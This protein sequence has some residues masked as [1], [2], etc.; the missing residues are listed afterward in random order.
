MDIINSNEFGMLNEKKL[1]KFEKKIRRKLPEEYREFLLKHNGGNPSKDCFEFKGEP[2]FI[3]YVYG[4]HNGPE[5]LTLQWHI[6][7]LKNRIPSSLV[8]FAGDPGGNLYC[9][10]IS[11]EKKGGIYFWNHETCDN[12]EWTYILKLAETFHDF[13]QNLKEYIDPKETETERI[14]RTSDYEALE[15]LLKNGYS[16][17]TEDEY[18]RTLIENATIMCNEELINFLYSKGAKIRKALNIAL[19]NEKLLEK[20]NESATEESQI[21]KQNKKTI[22]LLKKLSETK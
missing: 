1:V 9:I 3:D 7:I 15:E 8:P 20:I 6:K 13:F 2:Y 14:I 10:D 16:I 4:I 5:Y 12:G 21:M 11:D 17:E 19:E 22:N 18:G